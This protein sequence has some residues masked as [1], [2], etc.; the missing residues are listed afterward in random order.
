M[1]FYHIKIHYKTHHFGTFIDIIIFFLSITLI[2]L[3]GSL[4]I[5]SISCS[6]DFNLYI[7][8]ELNTQGVAQRKIN[9]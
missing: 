4:N 6:L 9:L 7:P 2:F 5:I 8:H 1:I 3:F